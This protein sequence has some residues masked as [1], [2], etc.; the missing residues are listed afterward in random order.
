MIAMIDCNSFYASCEQVFRPD[1]WGKPVVVLSNNDGCIIAAN[2]EA[3]SLA[4]IPMFEP[5]FKIKEQLIKNRVT[6]FSS[7]YTMYGEMSQRVMNILKTFSPMVEVYSIDESFVE[8]RG[9]KHV[10]LERYGHT[11]KDTI[12]QLTGLP[13]GVGIA[14]TKVLA[15]LANK[16]A[17][18]LE[19]Y[20]HVCV[21]DSEE[22]RIAAL[23]WAQTKDVW[24]LG[25]KHVERL[26]N[27]HVYTAYEFTQKPL[28]WVRKEM[29]VVGERLWRELRGESCIT[30]TVAPKPKK[31]IGTAKSFGKKLERLDLIEEACAYYISEV[32]EV[33][34]AQN[35]CATYI[36]VFVHTNYHSNVDKQYANSITVTMPIPTN[37]TFQ[38]ISEARKAL[39]EIYKPGYRYK[40]VGVNLSG[41]IPQEYVQGNL[42]QQPSKLNNKELIK[43]FDKI[44]KKYGKST[45]ASAM[46]GTRKEEWELIKKE[47][48][49]RY[50]TQWK[51]LL[52]IKAISASSVQL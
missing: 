9:M 4:H 38:L 16:M 21:I 45:V 36:Q 17:K 39:H 2:K 47:R 52:K 32:S 19:K 26:K 18:K 37:D 1:L 51:E 24:G 10:N 6:F 5:V 40:K 14:P 7:N 49:P 8:L 13:V 43:T 27:I 3:K 41:I 35:S 12:K 25:K 50:T 11:I 30:F 28:A 22:K 48:S 42:F 31:G 46:T 29:T 23:Q 34:R 15:K 44:N 20:D 33:L